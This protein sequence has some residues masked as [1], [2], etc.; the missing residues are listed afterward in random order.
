MKSPKSVSANVK[1]HRFMLTFMA[2]F[3]APNGAMGSKYINATV[4]RGLNTLPL[5][6]IR[7]AQDSVSAQL[8][9]FEVKEEDIYDIAFIQSSYLG[10]MTEH[11]FTQGLTDEQSKSASLHELE[12]LGSSADL[13]AKFKS[14]RN[15][16]A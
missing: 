15:F 10:H 12:D 8:R 13:A 3:K 14:Q 9:Y 2:T 7:N 11:E 1:L 4:S 16:D 5:F 6:F